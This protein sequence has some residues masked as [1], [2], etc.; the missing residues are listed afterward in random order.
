MAAALLRQHAD[1]QITVYSAGTQP[2]TALNSESVASLHEIG[3]I[4]DGEYPKPIDPALLDTVDRV[5][6]LGSDATLD[7]PGTSPVERWNTD[8]PSTRGITGPERMRLIRDDIQRRVIELLDDLTR[9]TP[10]GGPASRD[11]HKFDA[12]G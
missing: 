12:T 1:D 6:I 3:A 7:H 4:V 11:C 10:I 5:I 2:G 8:E 9:S